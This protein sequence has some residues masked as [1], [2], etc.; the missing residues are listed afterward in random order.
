MLK[1]YSFLPPST[2]HAIQSVWKKFSESRNLDILK[3]F[4]RYHG[5]LRYHR[6]GWKGPLELIESNPHIMLSLTKQSL[7]AHF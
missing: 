3:I 7:C 1:L 4:L 5:Y 2:E 6:R